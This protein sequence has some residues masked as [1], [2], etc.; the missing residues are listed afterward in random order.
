MQQYKTE[1]NDANNIV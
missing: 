1:F